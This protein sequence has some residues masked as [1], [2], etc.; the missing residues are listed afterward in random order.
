MNL[1]LDR[2]H[3]WSPETILPGCI[4]W[5]QDPT[6]WT[7]SREDN[8]HHWSWILLLQS[9][10]IWAIKH[11]SN[12]LENYLYHL[13]I[14][15]REKVEAYIV[16]MS[17]KIIVITDHLHDLKDIFDCLLLYGMGLNPLKCLFGLTTGRFLGYLV[18]SWGIEANPDKIRATGTYQHPKTRKKSNA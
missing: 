16:D 14:L 5:L 4:L 2:C 6:T 3:D 8:I 7:W 12:I 15:Y 17:I 13:W 1:W 11:S 18:T 9:H 10:A